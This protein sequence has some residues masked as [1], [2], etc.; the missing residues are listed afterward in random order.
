MVPLILRSD[1][2]LATQ[3]MA[4]TT[5]RQTRMHIFQAPWS[6][7]TAMAGLLPAARR[8]FTECVPYFRPGFSRRN[9]IKAY[10]GNFADSGR[11]LDARLASLAS[12]EKI[13]D[14]TLLDGRVIRVMEQETPGGGL[15]CTSIDITD[16]KNAGDI[17]A[18]SDDKLRYFAKSSSEWLWE[19]DENLLFVYCSPNIEQV[20]GT[21][22]D[23]YYGKTREDMLGDNYDRSVWA[24]HLLHLRNREPFLNFSYF[25]VADDLESKWLSVSGQKRNY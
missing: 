24:E 22:P 3:D 19:T 13:K 4:G 18:N 17:E 8:M 9:I 10:A 20:L 6:N 11:W 1:S 23:W 14:V 25:R 5:F 2:F 15:V 16:L 21:P 12:I 7:T